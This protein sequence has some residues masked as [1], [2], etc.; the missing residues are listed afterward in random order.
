MVRFL[1]GWQLVE[2]PEQQGTGNEW[3][4]AG[5][6][7]QPAKT[8]EASPGG[9]SF[10]RHGPP[11]KISAEITKR[12]QCAEVAIDQPVKRRVSATHFGVGAPS[13]VD[14]VI[15]TD[16]RPTEHVLQPKR[17]TNRIG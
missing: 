1:Q 3:I 2:E 14:D 6:Q 13:C 16:G 9:G 17:L 7:A 8:G 15:F 12:V 10:F 11:S 5:F 4:Y